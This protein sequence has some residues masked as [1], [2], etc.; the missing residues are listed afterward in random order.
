MVRNTL[1][2]RYPAPPPPPL[3]QVCNT[4][5][6]YIDQNLGKTYQEAL[7]N[8]LVEAVGVIRYYSGWADKT[9]GQTIST[10]SKKF[11]YTV[12][13]PIGVVAQII[14]WNYPLSMA[15]WKLGP[16]LAC[17]NTVVIKAAE[18]TPLSILLLGQLIKE[19]GFPPG[20]VN[21][22]NGLGS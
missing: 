17:G 21:I 19:A 14:P 5:S 2:T 22:L 13:Q 15:T 7:E 12:R 10:T 8:D 1:K 4:G 6:L 16:A 20:V 18:Q 3:Q 9:F 11:A